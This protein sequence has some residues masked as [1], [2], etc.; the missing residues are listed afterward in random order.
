MLLTRDDFIRRMI[1][2]RKMLQPAIGEADPLL[3]VMIPNGLPKWAEELANE[4]YGAAVLYR[5]IITNHDGARLIDGI[6]A[7]RHWGANYGLKDAKDMV[8][9][10]RDGKLVSQC[11]VQTDDES[12]AQNVRRE[13]MIAGFTVEVKKIERD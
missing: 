11:I 4:V 6:K 3:A 1:R 10:L 7:I 12:T 9:G 2:E 5:V 13:L 8:E